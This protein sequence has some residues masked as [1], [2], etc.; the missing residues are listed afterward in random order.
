[1]FITKIEEITET[2]SFHRKFWE[3]KVE[4]KKFHNSEE[5]ELIA[6]YEAF[7]LPNSLA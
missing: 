3:V 4:V 1:M 6:A 5:R 7:C 2:K